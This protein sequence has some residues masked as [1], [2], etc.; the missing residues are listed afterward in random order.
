MSD[1]TRSY[2]EKLVIYA[3][4]GLGAAVWIGLGGLVFIGIL[5]D[6]GAA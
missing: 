2:A 1:E 5:Q 4:L 3:L 6:A